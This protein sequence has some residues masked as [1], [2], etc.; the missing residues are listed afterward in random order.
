MT[1]P[2]ITSR[3]FELQVDGGERVPA[4]L[5]IPRA[6]AR[7]PAVLLLHGF[8]SRKERMADSIGRSL[9]QRGV[10]S[11]AVDLPLHGSREGA[12]EGL[13]I[14]NPL[15][16]VENWRLAISEARGAIAHLEA[17]RDVDGDRLGIAGYSLGAYLSVI[18][19]AAEPSI[20]AVCL[21][22]GGDLPEAT[23]FASIVRAIA[24]P[25]RAVRRLAGRPLFMI[26][27]RRDHTVRPEQARALFDA[28][29][30]PK[31]LY[32]YD[33]G[34]WPPPPAIE[35]A[36]E[37]LAARLDAESLCSASSA[38]AECVHRID[39]GRAP[40]GNVARRQSDHD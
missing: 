1:S 25:R 3:S 32:W 26:N 12:I 2:H 15:A 8:S 31:E 24:D 13:S 40:S 28:A 34:H 33:G 4:L 21:A 7:P 10:A 35:R 22:A 17:R 36:A 18:V 30:Q 19:A 38:S 23:P 5:Q 29:D 20:R 16:L 9:A 39:A 14:R 37:W 6:D 11:L 27:G